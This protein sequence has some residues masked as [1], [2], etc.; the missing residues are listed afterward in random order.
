MGIRDRLYARKRERRRAWSRQVLAAAVEMIA[1]DTN[2]DLVSAVVDCQPEYVRIV[3]RSR[4]WPCVL[5]YRGYVPAPG[6]RDSAGEFA[7]HLSR[8]SVCEPLGNQADVLTIDGGIE[9]WGDGYPTP[10]V[11]SD[12]LSG[13]RDT[14][15]DDDAAW[16]RWRARGLI[17]QTET[18]PAGWLAASTHTVHAA[19]QAR[20]RLSHPEAPG[21]E[22][23]DLPTA[24]LDQVCAV[25]ARHTTTGEQ[26]WFGV[27]DGRAWI[28]DT[29][30]AFTPYLR[31]GQT[32]PP[33]PKPAL[34]SMILYGPR[35]E[36][37]GMPYV[38]IA[39]PVT[40]A[41]ELGWDPTPTWF[42][43]EWPNLVWPTDHAWLAEGGI[44]DD[45][46]EV[47]GTSSLIDDL[48]AIV[49]INLERMT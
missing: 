4:W 7:E 35:A 34:P 44:D 15:V 24:V 26:C 1:A 10:A 6:R 27:W 20:A 21:Q 9:W 23:S 33:L 43:R 8:L 36:I 12:A 37:E 39:G 18:A 49:G 38:L 30:N 2:T 14:V 47:S 29:P 3:Y 28:N 40:A 42:W 5:G 22:F 48:D 32:A 19:Y 46:V 16:A 31:E 25:L 41:P 11:P 13:R 17:P 45:F